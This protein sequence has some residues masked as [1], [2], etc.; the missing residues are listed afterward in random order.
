V[1]RG[2]GEKKKKEGSVDGHTA[3]CWRSPGKD[4]NRSG[5]YCLSKD[6]LKKVRWKDGTPLDYAEGADLST[7]THLLIFCSSS[8]KS[9]GNAEGDQAPNYHPGKNA[10]AHFTAKASRKRHETRKETVE[11]KGPEKEMK[12]R[13]GKSGVLYTNLS[14]DS[15]KR[16][17][18]SDAHWSGRPR[19]KKGAENLRRAQGTAPKWE[20]KSSRVFT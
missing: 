12:K 4:F 6:Q 14:S 8:G 15:K 3:G 18:T 1:Q 17:E 13:D 20:R 5:W 19:G 2:L 7:P 11:G 9:T 10:L 16:L